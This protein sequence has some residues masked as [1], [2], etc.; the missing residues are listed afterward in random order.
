MTKKTYSTTPTH[1]PVAP[2][3]MEAL[4]ED[5][6]AGRVLRLASTPE[7]A[8]DW[9]GFELDARQTKYLLDMAVSGLIDSTEQLGIAEGAE[10][11]DAMA[12]N[13]P[14][15]G[16]PLFLVPP[17]QNSMLAEGFLAKAAD[18]HTAATMLFKIISSAEIVMPRQPH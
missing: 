1:A 16:N 3:N 7:L 6:A 2:I 13:V 8:A 4:S 10:R 14:G 12:Q 9:H 18:N 5:F 11:G 17:E 15:A